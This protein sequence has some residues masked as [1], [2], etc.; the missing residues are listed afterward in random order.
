MSTTMFGRSTVFSPWN[1][2][3]AMTLSRLNRANDCAANGLA[4]VASTA[5]AI[6]V[7]TSSPAD[8]LERLASN[9]GR[10]AGKGS[11]QGA[12]DFGMELRP[13]AAPQLAKRVAG[14]PGAAVGACAGHRVVGV[15]D[16][17]DPGDQGNVVTAQ[18]VRIAAAVRPLMVE[19]DDLE[20]TCQ[21]GH[22][23]QDPG[24]KHRML[25]DDVVLGRRQRAR[26]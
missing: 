24:A 10:E 13:R 16:V 1:T 20:V 18:A 7:R 15:G 4:I 26:F 21:E 5:H 8:T 9:V 19:L 2:S 25:L 12:D 22:R 6:S 3:T 17:D 14:R 11:S 23:A